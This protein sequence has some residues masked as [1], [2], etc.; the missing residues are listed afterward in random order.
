MVRTIKAYR[1]LELY[2]IAFEA[3][4]KIKNADDADNR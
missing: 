4:M 3:A 2:Q 1:N